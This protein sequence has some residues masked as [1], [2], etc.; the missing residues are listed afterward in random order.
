MSLLPYNGTT[1]YA[2]GWSASMYC[3]IPITFERRWRRFGWALLLLAGIGVSLS[4]WAEESP[5]P[6]QLTPEQRAY[7]TWK[8]GY[9]LHL[10]G[11]YRQ[12]IEY[13]RMSIALH[14]TAEA[15]TFL[16]WSLSFIGKL[17]EAIDQCKIAIEVDPDFGNPY[18]DIGVYLIDLGRPEE[19]IPWLERATRAN[20]YCCYEFAHY[21]L[22]R[23]QMLKGDIAAARRNFKRALE[24][25]PGYWPARKAL[26]FLDEKGLE[27]L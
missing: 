11:D 26:E 10:G 15:H 22:G 17:D 6:K 19:A 21:N 23:V 4:T 16:G 20:R 18:N 9:L 8:T 1:K 3:S 14:P 2:E 13:F 12:A 24:Y 7:F 5:Q 27:A 25:E